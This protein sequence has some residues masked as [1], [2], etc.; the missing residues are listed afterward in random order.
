MRLVIP[1]GRKRQ[2]LTVGE[3]AAHLA[4][5]GTT[6]SASQIRKLE[7]EGLLPPTSRTDGNYRLL[8]EEDLERLRLITGLRA[9]GHSLPIIKKAVRFLESQKSGERNEAVQVYLEWLEGTLDARLQQLRAL[10]ASL[11]KFHR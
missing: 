4:Q 9:L 3:A 1:L 6:V 7:R 8:T 5:G 2:G 10:K 11:R